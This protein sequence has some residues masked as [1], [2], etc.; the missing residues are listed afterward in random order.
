MITDKRINAIDY[1]EACYDAFD[2]LLPKGAPVRNLA[3]D[4]VQTLGFACCERKALRQSDMDRLQST[5]VYVC[6]EMDV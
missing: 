6:D 4:I 1:M 2:L 5:F 3:I